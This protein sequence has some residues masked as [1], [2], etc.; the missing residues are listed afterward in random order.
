VNIRVLIASTS[1]FCFKGGSTKS[2]S[3]L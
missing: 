3:V 2:T 1:P